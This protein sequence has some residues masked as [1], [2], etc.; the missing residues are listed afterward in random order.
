VV[1]HAPS[2][3]VPQLHEMAAFTEVH[4]GIPTSKTLG[5]VVVFATTQQQLNEAAL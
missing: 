4:M 5:F 1:L 2:S 3:F